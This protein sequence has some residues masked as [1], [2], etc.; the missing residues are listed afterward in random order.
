MTAVTILI[1]VAVFALGLNGIRIERRRREDWI[2]IGRLR[3]RVEL[4]RMLIDAK[5]QP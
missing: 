1:W 4:Q 3:E 2:E 5:K